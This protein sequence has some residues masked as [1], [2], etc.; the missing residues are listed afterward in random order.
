MSSDIAI[1]AE[2]LG[3]YYPLY[4]K[5]SDRLIQMLFQGHKSRCRKFR[6]LNGVSFEM[7]KGEAIGIIGRNGS[8]KST[9]L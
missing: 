8:G 3:K 4:S 6:A 9:L 2:G 5:P 1:A 7:K